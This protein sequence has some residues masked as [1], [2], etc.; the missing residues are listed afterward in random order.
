LKY[1]DE[2]RAVSLERDYLP[3]ARD[4][5]RR[6]REDIGKYDG[7]RKYLGEELGSYMLGETGILLLQWKLEPSDDLAQQLYA[8]I[9][10]KI[11]DRRG[12]AW[13]AAGTM[14]VA[15]LMHERTGE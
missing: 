15:L 13:G 2:T 14:L 7:V 11:G 3:S 8:A 12:V 9:E 5:A 6:H 10:G 4:L 1:L